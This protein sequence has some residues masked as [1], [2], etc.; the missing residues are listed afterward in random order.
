MAFMAFKVQYRNLS[1]REANESRNLWYFTYC[2]FRTIPGYLFRSF[3]MSK[4]TIINGKPVQ[5]NKVIIC[6]LRVENMKN[7]KV[8]DSL[9]STMTSGHG[10]TSGADPAED[11]V[12][13]E[14]FTN[15]INWIKFSFGILAQNGQIHTFSIWFLIKK[16]LNSSFEVRNG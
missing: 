16:H 2:G 3:L 11:Q 10:T 5:T 7:L 13:K 6:W 14:N 8:P 15:W 12:N 1:E 9:Y 4:Q